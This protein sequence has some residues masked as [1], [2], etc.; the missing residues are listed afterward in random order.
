ME[1]PRLGLPHSW[2]S[3]GEKNWSMDRRTYMTGFFA[4]GR[5]VGGGVFFVLLGETWYHLCHL[6]FLPDRCI[7]Y[8]TSY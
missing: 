5:E 7:F 1:S 8:R 4:G 6:N 2:T 3:K